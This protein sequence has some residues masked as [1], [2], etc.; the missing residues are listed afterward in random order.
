MGRYAVID[1]ETTGLTA[2][3]GDR[4]I[5]IGAVFVENGRILDEY[6]SFI[7][8]G[9]RVPG[10]ITRLTG[11]SNDMVRGAPPPEVVFPEVS[12][13]VSKSALVAHNAAFD[14]A[15]WNH[16]Q[17]R[18]GRKGEARF[19]CTMLMARRLY[20]WVQ[21]HKLAT[22]TEAHQLPTNGRHHRALA[23]SSVTAHLLLRMI[24]DLDELYP[25]EQVDSRFLARYQKRR[26]IDVRS[27]PRPRRR[28]TAARV[29][30][31]PSVVSTPRTS[32][33][34]SPAPIQQT[35]TNAPLMG[36]LSLKIQPTV[37]PKSTMDTRNA[38]SEESPSSQKGN[39]S[40]L[41]WLLARIIHK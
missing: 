5:E 37:R 8:P 17:N 18:L 4:A 35:H 38:A 24:K 41:W 14:R 20:P 39:A 9:V 2:R 28:A 1:F 13:F 19:L 22:L 7:D 36:N 12:Q 21:N 31:H 29:S 11:I 30:Q 27:K 34:K 33:R 15:F 25:E 40:W 16:E 23:D 26:K 3:G 6:Q 10:N 32:V